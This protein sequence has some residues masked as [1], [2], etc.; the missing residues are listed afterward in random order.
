MQVIS[1]LQDWFTDTSPAASAAVVDGIEGLRYIPRFLT[2][3]DESHLLAEIDAAPHW[4]NT[5]RRRVQHYGYRYDYRSRAIDSSMRAAE[6]PAWLRKLAHQLV[7]DRLMSQ[8]PDQAI[9]NEYLPGQGI[10]QHV[11]CEPCFGPEVVSISLGSDCEMRF[12]HVK[13]QREASLRLAQASA[14]V[15]F[16]AARYAWT[17]GIAARR[18]DRFDGHLVARSRRVSITFRRVIFA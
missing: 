5:L 15:L 7:V 2:A 16:G 9:V 13:E 6:F 18:T 14:L 4:S 8:T 1:P 12:V 11:D 3:K 17:H 10:S